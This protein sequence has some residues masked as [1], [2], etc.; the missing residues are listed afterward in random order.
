MLLVEVK[1]LFHVSSEI[2][3]LASAIGKFMLYRLILEATQDT[4]K[5]YLAISTQAYDG[6]LSEWLGVLALKQLQIP[7]IVCDVETEEVTQWINP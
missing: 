4:R 5:L 2:E 3:D 6:I 1:E 7:L